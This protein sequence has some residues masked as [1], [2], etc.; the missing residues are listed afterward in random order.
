MI[1]LTHRLKRAWYRHTTR[2]VPQLKFSPESLKQD[3]YVSQYGQDK[4]IN[5][6]FFKGKESGV[7]ID[8]GANDGVFLSNTLFFE[9]TLKWDGLAIEPLP[10]TFEKLKANRECTVVNACVNDMDGEVSF[11]AVDGYAEMLSGIVDRYDD[12]HVARI[13]RAQEKHGCVTKEIT[14]PCYKLSTLLKDTSFQAIDYMNIDTEGSEFE[15]IQSIDFKN[16]RIEIITVENNYH[17]TRFRKHLDACG[18]DLVAIVGDE[19]YRRRP[20]A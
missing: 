14:V 12:R 16:I 6:T 7:F 8:I 9:K 10:A 4:Y 5:E 20:N 19:I 13:K 17:D 15:I 11:M 2:N 18:Y 3:G 1:K